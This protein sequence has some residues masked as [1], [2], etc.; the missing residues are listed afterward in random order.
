MWNQHFTS[1]Y[2]IGDGQVAKHG[3]KWNGAGS[4]ATPS[5]ERRRNSVLGTE[6]GKGKMATRWMSL[7]DGRELRTRRTKLVFSWAKETS[8]LT[9]SQRRELVNE[10]RV[11]LRAKVRASLDMKYSRRPFFCFGPALLP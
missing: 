1:I 3:P 10:E 7:V 8:K 11:K 5:V 2:A 6:G 4:T 9:N